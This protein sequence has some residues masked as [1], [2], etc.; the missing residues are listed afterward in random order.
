MPGVQRAGIRGD[1]KL[2]AAPPSLSPIFD[3]LERLVQRARPADIPALLGDLERI[4]V[5]AW[6][7]LSAPQ[8]ATR[9]PTRARSG[10]DRLLT[11]REA[12]KMLGV[13]TRWVYDHADEIPGT[14]RLTPRCLR[15]SENA[16]K[17][18][19]ERRSP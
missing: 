19:L 3:D 12:A 6:L 13:T 7:R 16:L 4:R 5:M 11:A 18:W 1:T 9:A 2:N 15:F 10:K 17:R 8:V 14:Q